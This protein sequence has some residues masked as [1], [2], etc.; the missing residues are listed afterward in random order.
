MKCL[1]CGSSV[2][3]DEKNA[4]SYCG[5][6]IRIDTFKSL[7]STVGEL[8]DAFKFSTSEQTID[9]LPQNEQND[10][11]HT[12]LLVL[13]DRKLWSDVEQVSIRAR[14]K[15][16]TD[17]MFDIYTL[18]ALIS[19]RSLISKSVQEVKQIANSI[20]QDENR[21]PP[22]IKGFFINAINT[23]WCKRK[24]IDQFQKVNW[25]PDNELKSL[26]KILNED[27]VKEIDEEEKL[28]EKNTG[29][30]EK[31]YKKIDDIVYKTNQSLEKNFYSKYDN[32]IDTIIN[33]A[34]T[35]ITSNNYKKNLI[36]MTNFYKERSEKYKNVIKSL[37]NDF[38]HANVEKNFKE[39]E[40]L[41]LNWSSKIPIG[42][43]FK[44]FI[45]LVIISIAVSF[46]LSTQHGAPNY[47]FW[48]LL[49]LSF[50]LARFSVSERK[51]KKKMASYESF[52][53]IIPKEIQSEISE[54]KSSMKFI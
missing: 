50:L 30:I 44:R 22:N 14:N 6:V 19:Q 13:I 15:F 24:K 26:V 52:L 42:S 28:I 23:L 25:E 16:P 2:E 1:S 51:D 11:Y 43:F 36:D 7:L 47:I 32:G 37:N 5:S 39:I 12:H 3:K 35:K 46:Y 29:R 40:K 31:I 20:I 48:I 17:S 45:L 34:N 8:K 41:N 4:C 10:A 54:L 38:S 49:P 21:I 53:R 33:L 27:I 9:S 18:I